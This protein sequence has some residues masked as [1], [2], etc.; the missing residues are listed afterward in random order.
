MSWHASF[1]SQ[2]KHLKGSLFKLGCMQISPTTPICPAAFPEIQWPRSA[3]LSRRHRELGFLSEFACADLEPPIL[4]RCRGTSAGS[5]TWQ[6][7]ILCVPTALDEYHALQI[8]AL[9]AILGLSMY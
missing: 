4:P 5:S 7:S 1:E 2:K 8:R 3:A 9:H 6:R